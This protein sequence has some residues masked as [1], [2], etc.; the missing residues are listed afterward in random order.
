MTNM[1]IRQWHPI[2]LALIWL[3]D[4]ALLVV[5]W[6]QAHPASGMTNLGHHCMAGLVY[7]RVCY[8]LEMGKRT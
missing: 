5:F 7:P 6:L 4:L 3:I 1:A 2:Q 8:H